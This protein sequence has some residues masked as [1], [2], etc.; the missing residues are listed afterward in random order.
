MAP[1]TLGTSRLLLPVTVLCWTSCTL[2][3]S[4]SGHG[5]APAAELVASPAFPI[6]YY[7]GLTASAAMLFSRA[8]GSRHQRRPWLLLALGAT[9][10]LLGDL[11]WHFYVAD[12]DPQ[13]YPSAADLGYLLVFPLVYAGLLSLVRI[14]VGRLPAA[15]WLDGL[16]AGLGVGSV[17]AAF[18]LRPVL[19]IGEGDLPLVVTNLAYPVG[20][21]VLLAVVVAVMAVLRGRAG[22]CWWLLSAGF[23]ALTVT[24]GAFLLE[25][26]SGTHVHP[27]LVDQGWPLAFLLVALASVSPQGSGRHVRENTAAISVVPLLSALGSLVV[28][29]REQGEWAEVTSVLAVTTIVL[30]LVRLALTIRD[31]ERLADSHRLARTDVLTGLPNRRA[32][33]DRA[34]RLARTSTV[35]GGQQAVLLL[36]LDRF[37][38]VNDSL[39]HLM[40]DELLCQVGPRL[41]AQLRDGDTLAR[42]GGDEFG[43]VLT[44]VDSSGP[45]A[46]A[47]RLCRSLDE[48]FEL[49]GVSV[50]V[51]VSVG[52][53]LSPQH[54]VHA[55]ELL[56]RADV[57]MYDAKRNRAGWR[58]YVASEDPN[59]PERL[60][61]VEL[62]R[63]LLRGDGAGLELHYQP[64]VRLCDG[65]LTGV[66][67][68][69][70]WRH[71][72]QG[73]LYPGSFLDLV[74]ENGLA[75]YLTGHVL[76]RAL[77]Q[78]ARWRELG[79]DIPVAV[80]LSATTVIDTELPQ[81]VADRLSHHGLPPTSLE[82]EITEEFL[83]SDWVRARSVLEGVRGLGVRVSVDDFGTGYSSLSYLRDLP[84][85]QLKL[86][87]T[88][89]SRM[90]DDE[91]AAAL[92][93]STVSLAHSLGLEM[94]AEGVE[95][96]DIVARLVSFGCDQAQGY[97]L[98]RPMPAEEVESWL[99]VRRPDPVRPVPPAPSHAGSPA[100]RP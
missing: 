1:S 40:G 100:S 54:G 20:D 16:I 80:N 82:L 45:A 13:P 78:C 22:L 29:L 87:R 97:H 60:R 81:S 2:V 84:I 79:L 24:D 9:S 31:T 55:T 28:L 61:S 65:S 72:V 66:E 51:G 34:G 74:E 27:S 63:G 7:V 53:A 56:Q 6:A 96:A 62:L 21:L 67:A 11:F 46:V 57:A 37:K 95:T 83:M 44:G 59:S 42:L 75:R 5:V 33:Y 18:V 85:D 94:V 41:A 25:S 17:A 10:W 8:L 12:L 36:D 39:G 49:E 26:A 14:R 19:E 91:T 92:V 50:Q 93:R 98:G 76:D 99:A 4:L 64:K 15:T 86:D 90:E 3:I 71:P 35:E 30:T 43:V 77:E 48:P 47:E 70:R 68:L 88:F 23:V 38:E 73:L 69:V 89:I 52:I 32:F 58:T